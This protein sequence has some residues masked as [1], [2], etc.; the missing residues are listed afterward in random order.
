MKNASWQSWRVLVSAQSTICS[1]DQCVSWSDGKELVCGGQWRL[2]IDEW[3]QERAA[4]FT[5]SGAY[6]DS[7]KAYGKRIKRIYVQAM[8]IRNM[9]KKDVEF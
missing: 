6:T 3:G 2:M 1:G 7:N 4:T 8:R 5:N 9:S